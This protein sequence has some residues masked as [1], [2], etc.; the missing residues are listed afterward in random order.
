MEHIE[1]ITI[2]LLRPITYPVAQ[3]F[4]ATTV[5]I[6]AIMEYD[7][8]AHTITLDV[9]PGYAGYVRRMLEWHFAIFI[10]GEPVYAETH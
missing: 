6:V 1:T 9:I 10:G 5:G 2:D 3:R 4:C 7:E 8:T